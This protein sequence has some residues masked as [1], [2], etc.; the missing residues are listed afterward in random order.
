LG[1]GHDESWWQ[2]FMVELR[3]AGYDDVLSIEH[4]DVVTD[5]VEGIA[6]TVDILNRVALRKPPS[7][8]LW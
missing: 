8:G 2:G 4:D 3:V 7:L 6:K 5:P 1:H